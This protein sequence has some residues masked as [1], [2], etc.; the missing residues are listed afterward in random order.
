MFKDAKKKFDRALVRWLYYFFTWLFKLLPYAA[1]K[2]LTAFLLPIV[3]FILRRMRHS[4]MSTL[5]IAFGRDKSQ[6]EL[7]K[8]CSDC[9]Q[10][11]GRG[12]VE[13]AAFM[14][15]PEL[16]K[17]SFSF[18]GNSRE[19]LDA[20]L[21]EGNGVIGISAHFGNFPLMLL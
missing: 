20:A 2:A 3:Y 18:D 7:K 1:I 13:V 15:H 8:I 14:A 10:N 9:F 6:E 4:A 12:V 16:I 17:K 5:A 19:N 21:K 11:A